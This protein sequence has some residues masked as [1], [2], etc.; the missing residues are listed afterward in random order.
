MTD[1]HLERLHAWRRQLNADHRAWYE[2]NG[3]PVPEPLHP[4]DEEVPCR[5]GCGTDLSGP[6]GEHLPLLLADLDA[7]LDELERSRA[8]QDGDV[9]AVAEA[10]EGVVDGTGPQPI[11]H[12]YAVRRLR[13]RY[14]DRIA[15]LE[16]RDAKLPVKRTPEQWCEQY[17][18]D[19]ADPD[20]WRSK[21]A[22]AWDEPIALAD[23]LQRAR[24]S[25]ARN[26]PDID[27]QR[28]A[29]DAKAGNEQ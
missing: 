2:R 16:V 9:Q 5:L 18:V 21:D 8:A 4:A 12:E 13:K 25:T 6:N 1:D 17:G 10:C 26:V 23:F 24:Q 29:R 19:I 11:R 27:W 7:A 28:L 3:H 20:G 14:A 15:A 22:P